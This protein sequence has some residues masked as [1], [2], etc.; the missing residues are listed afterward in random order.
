MYSAKA[1]VWLVVP[2]GVW[3]LWIRGKEV[4]RTTV[5]YELNNFTVE[6]GISMARGKNASFAFPCTSVVVGGCSKV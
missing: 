5:V 4:E 2:F 3:V 6:F 1:P